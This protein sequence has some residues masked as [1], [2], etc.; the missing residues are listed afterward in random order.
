V[1]VRYT[2]SCLGGGGSIP[3][4]ELGSILAEALL[5]LFACKDLFVGIER[6][7]PDLAGSLY[8]EDHVVIP[9][10]ETF[11]AY[12]TPAPGD[13]RRSQTIS[14]LLEY[15]SIAR[16]GNRIRVGRT[17]RGANRHLCVKN[18]FTVT[19]DH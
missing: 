4:F 8:N 14:G 2:L 9:S 1:L 7:S 19:H 5:A 12:V 11:A 10:P 6:V 18:V 15:Q 13:I 3:L 16:Q 17:A